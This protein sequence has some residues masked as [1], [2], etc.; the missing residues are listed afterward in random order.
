M[1]NQ[2]SPEESQNLSPLKTEEK[3]LKINQE[4]LQIYL[5]KLRREQQLPLA[6]V[7]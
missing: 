1:K 6:I 5:D 4:K 3:V 2:E 7:S